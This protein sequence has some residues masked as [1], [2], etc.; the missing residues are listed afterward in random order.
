MIYPL[1]I[2]L[3]QLEK[4]HDVDAAVSAL[5]LCDEVGRPAHRR[6]DLMLGQPRLFAGRHQ[7]LQQDVVGLLELGRSRLSGL[8]G[9][10][11]LTFAH[12]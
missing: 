12:S 11:R 8:S 9:L 4:L 3:G 2:N 10:R 1:L 7:A 5:A 6:G